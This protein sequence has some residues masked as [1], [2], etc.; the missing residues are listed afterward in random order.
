MK[1]L[2]HSTIYSSPTTICIAMHVLARQMRPS[3]IDKALGTRRI[4]E[5]FCVG[6]RYDC[7]VTCM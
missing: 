2:G 4:G 1:R 5:P 3:M 7:T 6:M